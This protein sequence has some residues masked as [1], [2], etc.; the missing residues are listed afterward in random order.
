MD[1]ATIYE[2]LLSEL[3]RIILDYSG[4]VD[5]ITLNNMEFSLANNILETLRNSPVDFVI[6]YNNST[7]EMKERINDLIG[8]VCSIEISPKKIINE[9]NNLYHLSLNNLLEDDNIADQRITAIETLEDFQRL[10]DSYLEG[11]EYIDDNEITKRKTTA[12]K[13]Y[14]IGVIFGNGNQS[15]I[16]DD[17]DTLHEALNMT[18]LTEE[19]KRFLLLSIMKKNNEIYEERLEEK[20]E[21]SKEEKEVSLRKMF[22]QQPQ[23]EEKEKRI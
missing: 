9:I 12:E 8:K 7:H 18:N 4:E 20:K 10:I 16:I 19:E 22:E 1:Q 15:D 23:E 2:K 3:E 17:F 13:I 21:S 11:K 14:N 5:H 6:T